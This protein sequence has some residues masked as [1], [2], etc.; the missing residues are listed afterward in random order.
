ME[1]TKQQLVHLMAIVGNTSA[2]DDIY[3]LFCKLEEYGVDKYGQEFKDIT[4]QSMYVLD[5]QDPYPYHEI[6]HKIAAL[7]TT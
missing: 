7:V 4:G 6:E 5:G 2:S 3:R 1:L